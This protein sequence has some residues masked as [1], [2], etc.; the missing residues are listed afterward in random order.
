IADN[1]SLY[2]AS[3]EGPVIPAYILSD[4]KGSHHW[5]G[6]NRQHFLCGCLESL[7]T[8]LETIYGR[9]IIRCGD[10]VEELEKLARETGAEA[11][12]F[13]RDPDPF[14][15][16]TEEKL[17]RLCESLGIRCTGHDDV[18]LHTPAE[19]LTQSRTPYKVFTP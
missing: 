2:R 6:A 12:H 15:K 10:A 13:N 9:L 18:S 8:N 14:G 1:T 3:G 16:A 5:T 19:I 4:W 7:S 17:R 11:I